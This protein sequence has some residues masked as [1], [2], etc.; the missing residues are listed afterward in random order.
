M[1]EIKPLETFYRAEDYHQ[2]Y[3]NSHPEAAYCQVIINPKLAKL[4]E[5]RAELLVDG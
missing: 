2:N 4:R 3:F 1:T 5:K